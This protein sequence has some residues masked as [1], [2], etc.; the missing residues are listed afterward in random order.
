MPLIGVG[1]EE[2]MLIEMGINVSLLPVKVK[3]GF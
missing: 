1:S 3:M 2:D